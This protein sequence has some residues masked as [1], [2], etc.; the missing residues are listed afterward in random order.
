MTPAT[1]EMEFFDTLVDDWRRQTN[2]R[3]SF[4]LDVA[5]GLDTS[6]WNS[7]YYQEY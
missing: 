3:K 5:M 4:I 2:V 7:H 1:P 6:L